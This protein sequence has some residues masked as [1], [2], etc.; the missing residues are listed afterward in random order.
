MERDKE[1]WDALD[2]MFFGSNEPEKVREGI[3]QLEKELAWQ[4]SSLGRYL[5]SLRRSHK[6]SLAEMAYKARVDR[7]VWKA[8]EHDFQTPTKEELEA[9]LPDIREV[10]SQDLAAKTA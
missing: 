10:L 6:R 8:W 9:V 3:R 7:H 4:R 2:R 1:L 5:R